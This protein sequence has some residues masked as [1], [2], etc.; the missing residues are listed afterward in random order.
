MTFLAKIAAELSQAVARRRREEIPSATQVSRLLAH[1]DGW[2]VEDLLCTCG[3][4]DLPFVEQH[5]SVSIAIVLAGTFQY[6]TAARSTSGHLMTPGSLLLGNPGQS[7]ECSHDHGIGDRC[8][9]FQ[10]APGY[11]ENIAAD[12]GTPPDERRFRAMYLPSLRELSPIVAHACAELAGATAPRPDTC[13]NTRW[14]EI[15]LHLAALS[16]RMAGAA[17]HHE[18]AATPA[19][20]ARVT[21]AVRQFEK[22]PE[23]HPSIQCL[24][25]DAGLSP[26]HFLRTF[27]Q[28]TGVTPH[29]YIRRI[30]LRRAAAQ[31]LAEGKNILDV[32]MDCGFGDVSNFNRAFR[33]E[34]GMSP[35]QFRRHDL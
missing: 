21:R 31:L 2:R 30:R 3:R 8:L 13:A 24:A 11:F 35:R 7:F 5:A 34:F 23:S 20:F 10:F 16:A 25:A 29:R 12:A 33:S 6:R 1:G 15:G 9:S 32:V 14:E 18:P 26:Y 28:L 4:Y 19:A 22:R 27:E 17:R